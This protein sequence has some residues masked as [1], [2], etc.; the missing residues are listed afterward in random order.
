M[1][2]EFRSNT[3]YVIS[4]LPLSKLQTLTGEILFWTFATLSPW[5]PQA[6]PLVVKNFK[7]PIDQ[8]R[9]PA[10]IQT[11]NTFYHLKLMAPCH[12]AFLVPLPQAMQKSLLL[13]LFQ[14]QSIRI[15]QAIV[16]TAEVHHQISV[17]PNPN[18][19]PFEA[20]YSDENL[21]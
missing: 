16:K 21:I 19:D 3:I 6:S 11:R 2:R 12:L 5:I 4:C 15:H 7:N 18:E 20:L 17:S 13:P 9:H 10:A 1:R 14:T 8:F